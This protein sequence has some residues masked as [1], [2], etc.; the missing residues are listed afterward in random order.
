[1][2]HT[3]HPLQTLHAPHTLQCYTRHTRFTRVTHA[4]RVAGA[5]SKTAAL[6]GLK[7][8]ALDSNAIGD[9][10]AAALFQIPGPVWS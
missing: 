9:S 5:L 4:L 3:V 1:M 7:M 2:V 8:L 6:F 10:G